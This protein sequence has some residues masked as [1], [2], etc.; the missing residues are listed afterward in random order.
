MPKLPLILCFFCLAFAVPAAPT[1][2][3]NPIAGRGADPHKR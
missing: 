3:T 1:T 2:F